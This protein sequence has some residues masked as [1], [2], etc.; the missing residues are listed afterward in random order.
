MTLY[1]TRAAF[2]FAATWATFAQ[3]N[4]KIDALAVAIAAGDHQSI[5]QA[6]LDLERAA[7]HATR[8]DA[9]TERDAWAND[10][11]AALESSDSTLLTRDCL[12]LLSIL[13]SD[14][15]AR[16]IASKVDDPATADEAL[17]ALQ[18]IPGD[19]AAVALRTIL[20]RATGPLRLRIVEALAAR[21]DTRAIPTLQKLAEEQDAE[22]QWVLLD[23]LGSLG[24]APA[25]VTQ[26]NAQF[27]PRENR[28][29]ANAFLNAAYARLDQGESENCRTH[30][31]PGRGL[32][33][34]PLPSRRCVD[35][36]GSRQRARLL[37]PGHGLHRSARHTPRRHS[38]VDANRSRRRRRSPPTRLPS[39]KHPPKID[40]AEH[41]RRAAV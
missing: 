17:M 40:P 5:H 39:R 9:T 27:S 21:G 20:A 13:G 41:S 1:R 33:L 14:S 31:H 22:L 12:Y 23:A 35:R 11:A 28:I 15:H 37:P 16:A 32:L 36:N 8:P 24:V 2:V 25:Q 26:L 30:V 6:R 38:P 7:L 29:Y 18:R 4:E 19:A 10:L 3:A 34:L